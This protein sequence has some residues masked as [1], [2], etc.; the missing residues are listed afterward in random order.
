MRILY[1]FLLLTVLCG[2]RNLE[3]LDSIK[4]INMNISKQTILIEIQNK[5]LIELNNKYE[6]LLK[7]LKSIPKW[8]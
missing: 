8:K 2:C 3:T 1:I 4:E 7:E 5:N 6:Q